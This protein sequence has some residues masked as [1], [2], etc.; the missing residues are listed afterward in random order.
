MDGADIDL[1][2][3]FGVLALQDELI[4]RTQFADVCAGWALQTNQLLADLLEE[5]GW[6]TADDRREVER[7]VA[8]KLKRHRGDAHATL[9]AVAESAAREVLANVG[10]APINESLH[11]LAPA[12]GY[13]VVETLVK[14][15]ARH[16]RYSITRLHGKGGL[17]NVWV[18]RDVDLNRE[19]ALKEMK[20][21]ISVKPEMC[22]RFLKEAQI[23]G[24]LEHPNIVPVYELARRMEDDEPFYVMRFV[25]G[26]TLGQ[27]I[28]KH[29]AD[30]NTGRSAAG[31]G[32][33]R[34]LSAFVVVCQATAYAHDR[35]IIHRDLKPDNIALGDFG[36]V[37]VLD[38]GLAKSIDRPDDQ[39]LPPVELSEET[40]TPVTHGLCGT[41]GFMAPEQAEGRHDLVDARSDIYA[42]GCILFQILTGK[43][44]V[45]GQTLQDWV[46]NTIEGT[47]QSARELNP[48]VAPALE[49]ICNRARARRREDRYASALELAKDIQRYMADQ[50]VSVYRDGPATRALRWARR[51]V[52]AVSGGAA[53]AVTTLAALVVGTLLLGRAA[54]TERNLRKTADTNAQ[55]ARDNFKLAYEAADSL[56]TEVGDV[57]LADI[58]QMERV[59]RRL[60]EKARVKY[61]TFL[62]Q[63]QDDPTANWGAGRALARLGDINV[64]LGEPSTSIPNYTRA[65]SLLGRLADDSPDN[66]DFVRDL[67]GGRLGLGIALKQLGRFRPA[68]AEFR[69]AMRLLAPL[70]ASRSATTEDRSAYSDARYQLAALLARLTGPTVES[71]AVYREAAADQRALLDAFRGRPELVAKFGRTLNNLARLLADVG[72]VD[73]AVQHYRQ[74]LENLA[75][76]NGEPTHLPGLRWQAA[77]ARNNLGILLLGKR[78][79]EARELLKQASSLLDELRAEFPTV[80]AYRQELASIDSNLGLLAEALGRTAEAREAYSRAIAILKGLAEE[81]PETSAHRQRAAVG[82]VQLH[83]LDNPSTAQGADPDATLRLVNEALEI[84]EKLVS[85]FPDAPDFADQLG[86]S[87]HRLA[88]WHFDRKDCSAAVRCS[89]R[90]VER[91]D[92]VVLAFPERVVYRSHLGQVLDLKARACLQLLDVEQAAV[93]AERMPEVRLD[94]LVTH[95]KAAALLVE[96]VAKARTGGQGESASAYEQRAIRVLSRAVDRGLLTVPKTL[97]AP[98]FE[99]LRGRPDFHNLRERVVAGPGPRSA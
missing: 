99:L 4:D 69:E 77:R 92:A 34:L 67:A 50:A 11:R 31:L 78:P 86:A 98:E 96:C 84:Q 29:H 73:E 62:G 97:D 68:E 93:A 36:E 5:R 66:V 8:R 64:L 75:L 85:E 25:R 28:T 53:V 90:A 2:L 13:V 71:E 27:A 42:L 30:R 58:P 44:P 16:S 35:G 70:A 33:H 81:S 65:L 38:W 89:T 37:I 15:E 83:L 3:L 48:A 57:D 52:A 12:T 94:H 80:A 21:G 40:V 43:F 95:L 10:A 61:E 88:K 79:A 17:G 51:H 19:V 72:R 20:P 41:P 49:A 6:I 32:P 55:R 45:P 63:K 26:E 59:R 87:L 23:T 9:G 54:A 14:P 60:L 74:A 56:L 7:R 82:M 24:Q 22:R 18:A 91:L 1:N 46:R 76:S 47:V 39:G